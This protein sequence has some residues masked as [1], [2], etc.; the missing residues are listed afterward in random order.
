MNE[1][2]ILYGIKDRDYISLF[3]ETKE[4]GEGEFFVSYG[5]YCGTIRAEELPD[6][7]EDDVVEL[8]IKTK[9]IGREK[10]DWNAIEK[11]FKRA[12]AALVDVLTLEE[13]KHE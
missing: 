1:E 2:T 10:H 5:S 12:V 3:S 8:K 9:V 13:G 7:G 4:A 11:E 6:I